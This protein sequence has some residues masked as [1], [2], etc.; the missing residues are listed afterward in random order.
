MAGADISTPG[1]NPLFTPEEGPNPVITLSLTGTQIDYIDKTIEDI[2]YRKT[3]TWAAGV[4][5]T[6]SEWVKQ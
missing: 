4:I 6:I 3:F 2:T 1:E 5:V